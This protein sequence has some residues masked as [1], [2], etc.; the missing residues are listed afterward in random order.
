MPDAT[1]PGAKRS[2]S[3]TIAGFLDIALGAM[4]LI[5]ATLL[6]M[7]I[8]FVAWF[9]AV[10]Q[11]LTFYFEG[12]FLVA[13]DLAFHPGAILGYVALGLVSVFADACLFATGIQLL[14][15]SRNARRSAF[16]FAVA[17]VPLGAIDI[18]I[19]R[20]GGDA[21]PLL[22]AFAL[23][24]PIYSVAQFAAFFALPSWRALAAHAEASASATR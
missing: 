7:V 15:R 4:G 23:P 14:D 21:Q 16:L 9:V 6:A 13:P 3:V 2:R 12:H 24:I 20:L 1:L 18:V 17:I 10:A 5:A 22:L 8:G 19:S 11:W